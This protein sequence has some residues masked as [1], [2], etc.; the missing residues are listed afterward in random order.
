MI[1]EDNADRMNCR[2][3]VEGA[4]SPTTPAADAILNDKGVTIVPDVLANAGG[5]V[6]SYF[7]WVQNLQHFRWDEDA[8][9]RAARR[10]HAPG[11]PRGGRSGQGERHS[12]AAGGLRAGHRASCRGGVHPRLH[13]VPPS[14]STDT[15]RAAQNRYPGRV[16][17]CRETEIRRHGG[18][19]RTKRHGT[20]LSCTKR[21]VAGA[22]GSP[23]QLSGS[24]L[25]EV[26]VARRLLLEPEPVVLRRLLEEVGSVLEHVARRPR[27]R[28]PDASE[29]SSSGVARR[30]RSSGESSS[31]VERREAVRLGVAE[32][33]VGGPARRRL[34]SEVGSAAPRRRRLG[35]AG[36]GSGSVCGSGSV[37]APASGSAGAASARRR[38]G[39]RGPR[40]QAARLR[41]RRLRDRRLVVRQPRALPLPAHRHRRR[42]TGTRHRRHR[43]RLR[44][45]RAAAPPRA[46]RDRAPLPPGARPRPRALRACASARG[47]PGWHR[48]VRPSRGTLSRPRTDR[49]RHECQASPLHAVLA[50]PLGAV[51]RGVGGRDQARRGQLRYPA[52][53]PRRSSP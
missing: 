51:E 43:P 49:L 1:H 10:D 28:M 39:W 9:E 37:P 26:E 25:V 12:D 32:R 5:V 15:C 52:A 19:R 24:R 33:L 53:R 50:G 22:G 14:S 40:P 42:R 41:G 36:G 4:N 46:G 6:V 17:E 2:M 44:H 8:G 45:L 34:G 35:S 47:A 21:G 11:L 31:S 16:S 20:P 27:P 38:L 18:F 29:S 48:R 7:E 30:R 13:L 3:M 23:P